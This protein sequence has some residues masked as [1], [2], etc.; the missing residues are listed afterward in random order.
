MHEVLKMTEGFSQTGLHATHRFTTTSQ[1]IL[2]TGLAVNATWAAVLTHAEC[3]CVYCCMCD[4]LGFHKEWL[5]L[6]CPERSIYNGSPFGP[7][8]PG[9]P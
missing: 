6:T 5:Q 7:F 9:N 2:L 8:G 1:H 3:G 4:L